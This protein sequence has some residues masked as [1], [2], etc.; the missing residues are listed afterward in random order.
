[1]A[2]PPLPCATAGLSYPLYACDFDP[3]D[4][5]TLVVAGGG[6]AG[7]SGVNNK[8][9]I[10]THG[11]QTTL[12]PV[13]EID[14]SRDEDSVTCLAVGGRRDDSLLV[15]AGINSSAADFKRGKNDHFRV[16]SVSPASKA[17]DP[18][19]ELINKSNLFS[20]S[21]HEKYQRL[22][23]LAAPGSTSQLAAAASGLGN[24]FQIAL[25]ELM[26]SG[27]VAP[28]LRRMVDLQN[29]ANDIDLMRVGSANEHQLV[30]CSNNEIYTVDFTPGESKADF[31]DPTLVFEL[32]VDDRTGLKPTIRC[33]RYLTA[34]FVLALV[35]LPRRGG[36]MLNVIR[37]PGKKGE[38]GRL[39]ATS[40]LPRRVVQATALATRLIGVPPA[41]G[42]KLGQAQFA[43]AVAGHD[44]SISLYTL[45][46]QSV[47][48]VE[49][50]WDLLPVHTIF[51]AHPLQITGLAFAPF[52]MPK[53]TDGFVTIALA[54]ISMGNTVSAHSLP[55]RRI[56]DK[57]V[58]AS[59][60]KQATTDAP[61]VRYALAMKGSKNAGKTVMILLAVVVLIMA[62]AGQALLESLGESRE[63]FGVRKYFDQPFQI[64]SSVAPLSPVKATNTVADTMSIT[65]ASS[66]SSSTLASAEIVSEFLANIQAADVDGPILLHE[67][68][69]DTD[70]PASD[71]SP[72]DDLQADDATAQPITNKIAAVLAEEQHQ[73]KAWE[74]VSSEQKELWKARL[75]EAGH[76]A[77]HMG[78]AVFKGILFGELAGVVRAA[79]A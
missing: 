8:I 70:I 47:Q 7:R 66:A 56:V 30:Y 3:N 54:S 31:S 49:L 28:K 50:V 79:V 9:T 61:N 39:A 17:K 5:T 41:P 13:S 18:S 11:N 63:I 59:K 4:P 69:A 12:T 76:W 1:M 2:P 21:H 67:Y 36:V 19:I 51:E 10:L 16:F 24:E 23:R 38:K 6:G 62:V 46:H 25:A 48:A 75:K 35:N 27:S 52:I 73:G 57:K 71:Q 26:H 22:V 65:S 32:P 14:L 37:L 74:D 58:P 45:E 34:T 72:G 33:L 68:A 40:R 77:E 20:V 53:E 60:E 44:S 43:I 15:Y 55:L 78:E 42:T 29:E 64:R